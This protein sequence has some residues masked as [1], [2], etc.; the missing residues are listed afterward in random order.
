MSAPLD[1]GGLLDTGNGRGAEGCAQVLSDGS[2]YLPQ[3]TLTPAST[4]PETSF[5]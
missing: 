4:P 5:R 2:D 1:P 3:D